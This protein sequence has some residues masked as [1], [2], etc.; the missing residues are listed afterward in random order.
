MCVCMYVYGGMSSVYYDIH[1]LLIYCI[2]I[3]S[4]FL[5]IK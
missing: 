5:I 1:F 3:K 4:L 2:S